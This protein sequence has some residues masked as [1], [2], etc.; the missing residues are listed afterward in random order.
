MLVSGRAAY[1]I[2][3]LLFVSTLGNV[4]HVA[5]NIPPEG[6]LNKTCSYALAY[7]LTC[8]RSPVRSVMT[9]IEQLFM[10]E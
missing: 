10:N 7:S 6:K 5:Q 2:L 1:C 9:F 4:E 8:R 3:S